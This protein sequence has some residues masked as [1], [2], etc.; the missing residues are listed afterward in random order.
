MSKVYI[1]FYDVFEVEYEDGTDRNVAKVFDTKEKA[2]DFCNDVDRIKRYFEDSFHSKYSDDDDYPYV[3]LIQTESKDGDWYKY[4]ETDIYGEYDE[5]D[6]DEYGLEIFHSNYT[7]YI[8]EK[9]ME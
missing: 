3:K 6:F 1:V 9:E 5:E 8:E 7:F 2:E 4:E